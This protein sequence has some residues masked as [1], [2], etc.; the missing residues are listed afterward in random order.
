MNRA[1]FRVDFDTPAAL[2]HWLACAGQHVEAH[3]AR[4]MSGDLLGL[5]TAISGAR[6]VL[7]VERAPEPLTDTTAPRGE[8]DAEATEVLPP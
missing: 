5:D 2:A 4:I 1:I 7:R 3:A 8:R 6:G